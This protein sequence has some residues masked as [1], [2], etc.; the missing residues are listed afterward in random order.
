MLDNITMQNIFRYKKEKKKKTLIILYSIHRLT[1]KLQMSFILELS[2]AH[3][4]ISYWKKKNGVGWISANNLQEGITLTV[5][6]SQCG[7]P[8]EGEKNEEIDM[9]IHKDNNNNMNI[10]NNN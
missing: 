9:I 3:T 2:N 8:Y 4:N 7:Q 1:S 6:Q 5:S 10:N